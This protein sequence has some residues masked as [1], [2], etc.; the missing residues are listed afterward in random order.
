MVAWLEGGAT[1][2]G[3]VWAGGRGAAGAV[4]VAWMALEEPREVCADCCGD[5]VRGGGQSA[6]DGFPDHEQVRL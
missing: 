1:A 3:P 2:G 4:V 5:A 6:C